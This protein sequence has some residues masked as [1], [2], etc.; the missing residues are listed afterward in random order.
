M[1]DA[2]PVANP[3]GWLDPSREPDRSGVLTGSR[4]H[5]IWYGTWFPMVKS[6]AVPDRGTVVIAH[7]FGEYTG[8]YGHL[9]RALNGR[10]YTVVAPDLRGHGRSEGTRF[11]IGRFDDF[12]DD[13]EQII[14]VARE[15]AARRGAGD[16][17]P[18]LFGHSMGGLI[19]T[20]YVLSA[21]DQ[22]DL[23]GLVLSSPA[24]RLTPDLPAPAYWLM[25]ALSRVLPRLPVRRGLSDQLSHDPEV[26]RR[27]A[28]DPVLN[29]G[30]VP[31]QMAYQMG[32]A[33][34]DARRQL[35]R[36]T[37]PTLLIYAGADTIV[38][39]AGSE[40]LARRSRSTDLTVRP[41]PDL[42]HETFNEPAGP[43]IVAG[44]IDWLDERAD[45]VMDEML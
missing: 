32:A 8:R 37:L 28:M 40:L 19:A 22:G 2:H 25:S 4:D 42:M 5:A 20:R 31:L 6:G 11:R 34:R 14:D 13:L 21:P 29:Q 41:M 16:R 38:D 9:I 18:F 45:R 39:P 1:N 7:G 36:I 3:V 30:P 23:S 43:E 24:L 26:A 15:T 27:W 12:V 44:V 10:G 17:P 35:D 33:G